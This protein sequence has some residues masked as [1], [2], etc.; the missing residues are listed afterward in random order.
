MHRFNLG[1]YGEFDSNRIIL[2]EA[3]NSKGSF[4]EIK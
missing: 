2:A 4:G 1:T 3:K